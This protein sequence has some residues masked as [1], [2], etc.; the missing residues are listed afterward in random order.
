MDDIVGKG[1]QT[2]A[3]AGQATSVCWT[4]P[5]SSGDPSNTFNYCMQSHLPQPLSCIG[6]LAH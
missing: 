6:K 3:L 5:C 2:C 1:V 4:C